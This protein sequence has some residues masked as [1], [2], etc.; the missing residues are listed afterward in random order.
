VPKRPTA[1]FKQPTAGRLGDDGQMTNTDELSWL[2]LLEAGMRLGKSTDAVRSMIRRDKL[3]TRKGN[4]G[5]LLIGV[6]PVTG[7]PADGLPTVIA[8]AS[9]GQSTAELRLTLEELREELMEAREQLAGT[10]ASL[11]AA[12]RVR[13]AEVGPLRELAD[14]LTSEL[15]DA[16]RE[17]AEE[18]R[19]LAEGYR[20]WWRRLLG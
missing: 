14:R 7:Q 17:L 1:K 6:P 18:R 2:P 12:D 13:A 4:D 9:D 20:P 19:A 8:Q 15:V 10:K 11:E 16:R 5:R 3:P